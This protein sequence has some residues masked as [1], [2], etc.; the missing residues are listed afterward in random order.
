MRVCV[1]ACVCVRVCVC[2]FS[3]MTARERVHRVC[4]CVYVCEQSIVCVFVCVWGG[5]YV[6]LAF[7]TDCCVLSGLFGR[8]G[9]G[10]RLQNEG[11]PEIQR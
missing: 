8:D 7:H 4:V 10:G 5:Y 6:P 2:V 1:Y 9:E 3:C 11:V